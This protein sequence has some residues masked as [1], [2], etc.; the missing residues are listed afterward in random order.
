MGLNE[1]NMKS[2]GFL[3][4]NFLDTPPLKEHNRPLGVSTACERRFPGPTR[5]AALLAENQTP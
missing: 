2:L 1:I 4:L 5:R 3:C